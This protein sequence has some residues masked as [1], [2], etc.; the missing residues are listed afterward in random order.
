MLKPLMRIP[1]RSIKLNTRI[2]QKTLFGVMGR[3]KNLGQRA[4]NY[5]VLMFHQFSSTK[6]SVKLV[7]LHLPEEGNSM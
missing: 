3:I 5:N 6:I 4:T 7:N 2:E 1:E